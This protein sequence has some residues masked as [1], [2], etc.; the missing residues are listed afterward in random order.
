MI[1]Q[2]KRY[3]G[4]DHNNITMGKVQHFGY[5][6]YHGIPQSYYG[7]YTSQAQTCD[8]TVNNTHNLF[9]YYTDIGVLR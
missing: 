5:S 3:I 9:L 1:R 7:I 6:V 4:P 2:E 8:Q